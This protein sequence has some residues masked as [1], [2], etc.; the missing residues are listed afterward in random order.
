MPAVVWFSA[1]SNVAEE[2]NAG[3][4]FA[5]GVTMLPVGHTCVAVRRHTVAVL[6][7][8]NSVSRSS[9]ASGAV[10]IKLWP[11]LIAVIRSENASAC[12]PNSSVRGSAVESPPATTNLT[13]LFVA[14]SMARTL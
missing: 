10:Q 7:T 13:T 12:P 8:G 6:P 11:M 1:A 3:A 9:S 4:A 14:T 2:L 5:A